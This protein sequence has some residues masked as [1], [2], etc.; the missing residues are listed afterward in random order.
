MLLS[1][2]RGTPRAHARGGELAN[3]DSWAE[4][5]AQG[6]GGAREEGGILLSPYDAGAGIDE[7]EGDLEELLQETCETYETYET[8][9]GNV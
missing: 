7:G 6:S 8:C 1:S 3:A 2:V 4:A 5:A 9:S